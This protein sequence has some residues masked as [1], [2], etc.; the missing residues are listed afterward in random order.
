MASELE[1]M[2]VGSNGRLTVPSADRMRLQLDSVLEQRNAAEAFQAEV[3]RH[4]HTQG[5]L[6]A[7]CSKLRVAQSEV[8]P[9]LSFTSL[10]TLLLTFF[11]VHFSLVQFKST[12]VDMTQVW[13]PGCRVPE[14]GGFMHL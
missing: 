4:R 10:F 1:R 14:P 7:E 8:G 2:S 12:Y 13:C 6:E 5:L 9:L 3:Q 11:F